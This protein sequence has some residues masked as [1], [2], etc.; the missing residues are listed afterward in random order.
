MGSVER[1]QGAWPQGAWPIEGHSELANRHIEQ[2][3]PDR[4]READYEA[5]PWCR[6]RG[7]EC[8]VAC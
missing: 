5:S 3:D 8:S 6:S 7:R 2:C 4:G 1:A